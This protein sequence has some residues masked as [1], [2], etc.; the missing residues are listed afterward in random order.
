MELIAVLYIAVAVILIGGPVLLGVYALVR[1]V[2][3]AWH[4]GRI[5]AE[6]ESYLRGRR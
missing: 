4:R 2:S 3:E 5:A 6:R 1:V